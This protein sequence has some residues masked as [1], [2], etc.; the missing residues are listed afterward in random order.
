MA[1]TS[2]SSLKLVRR[3]AGLLVLAVAVVY[4]TRVVSGP[5]LAS[6]GRALLRDPLGVL[7]ALGMYGCAFALRAWSW[8]RVLPGL[9]LAHSWSALHVSL[10]GNH[11]LPFRLGEALRVTT[12]LRRTRLSPAPVVASTVTLRSADL[13]AVA[14][15]A[16]VAAPALLTALAGPWLQPLIAVLIL[17]TLAGA[18]WLTRLN[19]TPATPVSERSEGGRARRRG[20]AAVLAV[21]FA[22]AVVAWMLE[23]AVVYEVAQLAGVALTPGEAVAVTAVTIA[24]Q[25]VAVTPGGFGSYEAAATAALAALGV[26]PGPAFAVALLT[27]AL[28]TAYSLAVG[29]VALVTPTKLRLPRVLPPRP[30][31]FPVPPDAPVVVFIPVF[32]EE[33]TIGEV[34]ER[35]PAEISGRPL[36]T[37]VIDDGSSDASARRALDAG[38]SVISQPHNLGLGAAVRRGLAEAVRLGPAAVVYLDADLEYFPE[39]I[40]LLAAPVLSGAADYVVGSRFTG[41]I[42]RMLPH[43]R[44]GNRVLTAWVRWMTRH[45]VTDGQSG[46]RAFS[47]GAA[48]AAEVIH[49]YNYAQVLTLDLLAKGYRYHE[50]PIRYAFRSTGASFVTLGR[51]LRKVIPAVHR[52]LNSP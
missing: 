39:D 32:N 26:A 42:G 21:V 4:L 17:A 34:V 41:S 5:D 9:S 49:D 45:D 14:L 11:V 22:A 29:G 31:P 23:A 12:V 8:C 25:T 28:K 16:L 18:L 40:E 43:R 1:A 36:V 46:Y 38:A 13:A 10:L 52:E 3:G 37:I 47:P 15:L 24:A 48:R 50:V 2:S 27:H 20:T 7:T 30:G 19:A 6:A 35:L 44:L 51:Y 33:E